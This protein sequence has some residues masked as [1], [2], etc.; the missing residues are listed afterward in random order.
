VR[1]RGRARAQCI[2]LPARRLTRSQRGCNRATALHRLLDHPSKY[3]A[4]FEEALPGQIADISPISFDKN[5]TTGSEYFVGV[6]GSFGAHQVSPRG[7]LCELLNRLV[8]VEGIISRCTTV[9]PKVVSTMHYCKATKSFE[10]RDY[11][12]MTCARRAGG[13]AR[14]AAKTTGR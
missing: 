9:H 10:S 2:L 1:A 14:V 8:C 7:L 11:R 12:D 6:T 13:G 4:A 3:L 5:K